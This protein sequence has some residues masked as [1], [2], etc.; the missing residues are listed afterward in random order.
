[1]T[2]GETK[3]VDGNLHKVALEEVFQL[4]LC[5]RIGKVADVQAATFGGAGKDS[6]VVGSRLIVSG[7]ASQRGIGQSV[8]DVVDGGGSSVGN[9]LHDGRHFVVLMGCRKCLME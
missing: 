9:F 1:M 8:G 7:L 6:I 2:A 5:C 4:P 3:K